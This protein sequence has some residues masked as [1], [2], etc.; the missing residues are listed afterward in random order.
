MRKFFTLITLGLVLFSCKDED[1]KP[2][3]KKNTAPTAA[4]K[5]TTQTVQADYSDLL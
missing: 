5:D 1:K 4:V 3:S 2:V